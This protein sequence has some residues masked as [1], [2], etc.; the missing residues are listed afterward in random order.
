MWSSVIGTDMML[1]SLCFFIRSAFK[2]QHDL[3]EEKKNGK[4]ND[5]IP[6]FS[7]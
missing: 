5:E 3:A 4:A 1:V 2:L 6:I 7:N